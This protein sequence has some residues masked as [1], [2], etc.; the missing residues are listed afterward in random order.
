MFDELIVGIYVD[1]MDCQEVIVF[2]GDEIVLYYFGFFGYVLFEVLYVLV[3]LV[4][5]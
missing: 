3:G 2:V 1:D 5:Q 4:V